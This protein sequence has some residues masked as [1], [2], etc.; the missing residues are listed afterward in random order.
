MGMG[1]LD[2]LSASYNDDKIAWYENDGLQNFSTHIITT[3]AEGASSVYAADVDGDGDMDV[4]SASRDDGQITWF[5]NLMDTVYTDTTSTDTTDIDIILPTS[6]VL[7]Q[8][9]PNPFNSSTTISFYVYSATSVSLEIYDITGKVV[10]VLVDQHM[11]SGLKTIDFDANSLSSGI[12]FYRMRMGG[13][14]KTR[15]MVLIK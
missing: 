3:S 6:Y 14:T 15:K 5:E 10:D 1:D 8:N 7:Y 4:L 13:Y 9:Y 12:Y 2:V 11:Q